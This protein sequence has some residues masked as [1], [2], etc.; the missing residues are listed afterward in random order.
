MSANIAL[1]WLVP[2]MH[3]HIHPPIHP[4][5]VLQPIIGP[6]LPQKTP[7]FFPIPSSSTLASY[8]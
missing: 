7:P 1:Y 8:S 4:C 3:A 6:G 2:C 5:T